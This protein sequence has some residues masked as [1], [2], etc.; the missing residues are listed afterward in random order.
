MKKIIPF[1]LVFLFT[2][3][4]LGHA[5]S[6]TPYGP[7]SKRIG[8]GLYFGEPIGVTVKGYLTKQW[9]LNGIASWS[10]VEDAFTLIGDATYDLFDLPENS[11]NFSLPFYAGVGAKLGFG[12]K[13]ANNNK[14]IFA[15]H[16]PVGLAMQFTKQPIEISLELAPGVQMTPKTAFDLTG[17]LAARFYF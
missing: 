15:V 12:E 14:T 2:A 3:A 16:I 13:G 8:A 10:F 1:L 6:A 7:K 17:G 11:A 5:K 4:S 9:A